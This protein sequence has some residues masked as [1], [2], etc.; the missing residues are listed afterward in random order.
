MTPAA[1]KLALTDTESCSCFCTQDV[2]IVATLRCRALTQTLP[3]V[4]HH[5]QRQGC[6]KQACKDTVLSGPNL[7]QSRFWL[8]SKSSLLHADSG[9]QMY[10]AA[11]LKYVAQHLS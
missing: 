10:N 6:M 5:N 3:L 11:N 8:L 1:G 2:T 4:Q 9:L 7:Q